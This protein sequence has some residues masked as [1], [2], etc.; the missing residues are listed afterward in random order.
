MSVASVKPESI[1]QNVWSRCPHRKSQPRHLAPRPAMSNRH[2]FLDHAAAASAPILC[3]ISCLWNTLLPKVLHPYLP[4]YIQIEFN[5]FIHKSTE[6]TTY[7][8]I[9]ISVTFYT[10]KLE[11]K[12]NWNNTFTVLYFVK[13]TRALFL[14]QYVNW[15]KTKCAK[16]SIGKIHK[17]LSV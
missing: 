8:L 2:G 17:E 7:W 3:T 11:N 5:P 4:H 13:F 14:L 1:V 6:Q 9:T 16:N 15:I 10:T 12:Q